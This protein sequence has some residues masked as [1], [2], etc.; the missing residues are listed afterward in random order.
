MSALDERTNA[1]NDRFWVEF[2]NAYRCAAN[3]VGVAIPS[4]YRYGEEIS[5]TDRDPNLITSS[6]SREVSRDGVTVRIEIYRLED[7]PGWSLEVVNDRGTSTVW[8]ELFET[9]DAADAA[10]HEV[11]ATEGMITFL[12]NATV[13]PFRR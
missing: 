7:R 2:A 13:I 3:G 6:L 5:M 4:R 10:F 9:D 11:V 1:L 8:D 12:D